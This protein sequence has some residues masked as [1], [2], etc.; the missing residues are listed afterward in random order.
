M[1]HQEDIT[2]RP[3]S[4]LLTLA[5]GRAIFELGAVKALMPLARQL[6][7]GD[8]HGVLCLPGFMASERSFGPMRDFL[9]ARNYQPFDWD[10]GR[11][12][13]LRDGLIEA[14]LDRISELADET[15][16]KISLIGWSLG[17]I[18]AR[19]L[20]KR[21]PKAIRQVIALGSPFTGP[22]TATH[23]YKLYERMAGHSAD[24]PP[25]PLDLETVP[26]HPFTSVFTRTDG[27]VNWKTCL[28]KH[29]Q[30]HDNWEN[31]EVRA[32]HCGI[33]VNPASFYVIADRLAQK[34]GE[35]APFHY[36]GWRQFAFRAGSFETG[37]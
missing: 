8:G 10:Q 26:P 35:W 7:E 16:G 25:I 21:H 34:E 19:E 32:S 18:F 24:N 5:E 37:D 11:N 22:P 23:A 12:Y 33:G 36:D 15:G 1:G 28:Q 31:I 6:P 29:A 20:A 9:T 30:N 3:P 27:I 14:L 17:G 4:R 13:G 2:L